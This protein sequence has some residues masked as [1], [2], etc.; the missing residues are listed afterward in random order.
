MLVTCDID[1]NLHIQAETGIIE[2]PHVV[3]VREFDEHAAEKFAKQ[4]SAAYA[5]G[6]PIIPVIIDSYGGEIYSLLSMVDI[7]KSTPVPVA[8]IV[9]GKAMSAGAILLACGTEGY[10]FVGHR[11][12]VMIHD[13]ANFGK[14]A[15]KKVHEIRADAKELDRLNEQI[16]EILDISSGKEDG[17]FKKLIDSKHHADWFL[18]PQEAVKHNI[19]NYIGIPQFTMAVRVEFKLTLQRPE[20]IVQPSSFETDFPKKRSR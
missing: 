10:R 19:A 5:T 4:M 12:T 2:E 9:E 8:T 16:F 18:T 6:Q 11:A 15:T 17:H 1:A 14:E 3:R 20:M 7:I 13:A